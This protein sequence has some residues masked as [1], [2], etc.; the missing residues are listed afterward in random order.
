[1]AVVIDFLGRQ[2]ANASSVLQTM[3]Y[4]CDTCARK[5][6]HARPQPLE[7]TQEILRNYEVKLKKFSLPTYEIHASSVSRHHAAGARRRSHPRIS[8]DGQMPTA[9]K[10]RQPHDGRSG[11]APRRASRRPSRSIRA[12]RRGRGCGKPAANIR[13]AWPPRLT[14]AHGGRGKRGDLS[15]DK[16]CCQN[17]SPM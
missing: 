5:I 6:L 4:N 13:D 14:K 7:N 16:I 1:M 3:W 9:K 11:R 15:P 8:R 12:R 2:T 17:S 10:A